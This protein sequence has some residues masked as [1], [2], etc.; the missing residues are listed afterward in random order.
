MVMSPG[1]GYTWESYKYG[2]SNGKALTLGVRR[3]MPMVTAAH[4]CMLTV[5]RSPISTR[6]YAHSVSIP[7]GR[8]LTKRLDPYA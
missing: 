6:L 4:R 8:T 2:C 7:N 1:E 5:S 3:R